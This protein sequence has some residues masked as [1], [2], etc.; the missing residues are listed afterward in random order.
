MKKAYLGHRDRLIIQNSI[1]P[2]P[3]LTPSNKALLKL[4]SV[5]NSSKLSPPSP[6]TL[7]GVPLYIVL[8][9]PPPSIAG[10]SHSVAPSEVPSAVVRPL[11]E[12]RALPSPTTASRSQT[13]S[14][15][16]PA[17][18]SPPGSPRRGCGCGPVRS[19][20]RRLSTVAW[21]RRRLPQNWRG[22]SLTLAS[23]RPTYQVRILDSNGYCSA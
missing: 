22:L 12:P 10:S 1:I 6:T 21:G 11:L 16:K 13:P 15:W 4:S 8:R 3:I 18:G 19:R 5:L 9:D 17:W 7:R 2:V 14:T 20:P 23:R